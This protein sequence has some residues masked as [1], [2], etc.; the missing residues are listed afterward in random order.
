MI[1]N[2]AKSLSAMKTIRRPVKGGGG[3]VDSFILCRDVGGRLHTSRFIIFYFPT[4]L[5]R[6]LTLIKMWPAMKYWMKSM[7]ILR[8]ITRRQICISNFFIP[9]KIKLQLRKLLRIPFK[10]ELKN[11]NIVLHMYFRFS[12]IYIC[13]LIF[14]HINL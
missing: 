12:Y 7:S 1:T 2:L 6:I 5:R 8:F 9:N 11:S 13:I 4:P 3:I 10:Q 14:L